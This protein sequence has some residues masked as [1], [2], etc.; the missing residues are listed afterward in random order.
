MLMPVRPR[1]WWFD[2][3]LLAG[4]VALTVALAR[5]H[6]LTLDLQVAAWVDDHRPAPLGMTL[7]VFNYLGQGGQ[8]LMSTSILLAGLVAWRRRSVRPLLVIVAAFLVTS[9][10]IGPLKIWLDRAAPHFKGPDPEILFNPAAAGPLAMSYPSGHVANAVAWY[11][12]I[13]LLAS[14]LLRSLDRPPLSPR[15][16]TALR[17]LPPAIVFF[18]TTY[19]AY[20]WITDSV[21]GLLLGLILARLLTRIPWD[22]IPL[23]R[24]PNGVD[25]PAGLDRP[26]VAG[27]QAVRPRRLRASRA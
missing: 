16:Y 18:T 17:V 25:R 21:A 23:P 3:A 2:A 8:V 9:A 7:R 14:A 12:V 26:V 4:F 13:A 11:A 1:G 20:H 22:A 6:L 19:L 15:A 24:L 10:T 5:G 27:E